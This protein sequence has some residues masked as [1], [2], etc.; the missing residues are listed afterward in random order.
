MLLITPLAIT[1]VSAQP[2]PPPPPPPPPAGVPLDGGITLLLGG[3]AAYG[4]K[5]I[6]GNKN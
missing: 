2:P 5:K 4:A 3:L 1:I 6:W